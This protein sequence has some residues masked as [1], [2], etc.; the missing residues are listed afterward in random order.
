MSS[1]CFVA[2]DPSGD[3]HA[4]RLIEALKHKS[5]GLTFSG[6][7]GK[8]MRAVGVSLLDDLTQTA[9]I[10]PFDAARHLSKFIRAKRLLDEHLCNQRPDLVVL[11]DFG[12]FNLPFIAPLVKRYNI[13][14]VYYISPQLWA[15]G[16]FRLRYVRKYVDHMIVLFP[17][18]ETFY[19]KEGIPV[20][21]VGHPLIDQAKPTESIADTKRKLQL[22]SKKSLTIGLLPG[23]R[24]KEIQRH[25]PMMIEAAKLIH[26]NNPTTQWVVL[27]AESI[28]RDFLQQHIHSDKFPIHISEGASANTLQILDAV[29]VSSGTA[30]LE[31]ALFN[32]P[33]VVVYK[34]SWLTYLFAKM[35]VQV[36]FIAMVNLIAQNELVPEFVQNKATPTTIANSLQSLLNNA[37][38][39]ETMIS[40]LK[41]ITS[42]LGKPGAIERA[43][44]VVLKFLN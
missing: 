40:G 38:R 25:L 6:L 34:T 28:T 44:T 9:A 12:D 20:T 13:P 14:I 11:V 41:D 43:A 30:T 4:S 31:T 33:M 18:E 37:S 36:P 17:F 22:S 27:K 24:K 19:Q 16:R 8:S 15:W 5:P 21:W 35:V 3:A 39:R 23:S 26:Q 2:G 29:I 42:R 1:I 10:G 32:I 7:G